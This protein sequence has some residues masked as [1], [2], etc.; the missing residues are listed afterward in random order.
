MKTRGK[1]IIAA[2]VLL[3]G[4]VMAAM[5][6]ISDTD[7]YA[8]SENGGWINFRPTDGGVTVFD[9]YLSGYAWAE[10]IGWIKL[11]A[12][13]GGPYNNTDDTNWGVNKDAS[14]NLFGYAWSETAGWINFD[15]LYSQVTIDVNGDFNGHA[16]SENIGWIKFNN[17]APAYMV[18]ADLPAADSGG[19]G[20]GFCFIATAAFGSYLAPDVMVLRWFRDE[21]LLTN[22][23]GRKFVELYYKYSPPLADYIA[24]HKTM[25]TMT[26]WVL[27]PFIYGV[28]F[29]IRVM[30][31][32]AGIIFC[33]CIYVSRKR[34]VGKIC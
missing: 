2:V 10:N 16:W 32:L 19:G 18:S 24:E 8:W 26:R 5:G 22:A 27:T 12:D 7:K 3:A 25:R 21:K 34:M 6:N 20:G 29:P 17:S 9:T 31:I 28:K 13:A 23:P 4:I 30:M 33:V 14:G 11:G 15:S 1:G